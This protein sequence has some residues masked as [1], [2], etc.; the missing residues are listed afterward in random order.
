MLATWVLDAIRVDNIATNARLFIED[1]SNYVDRCF[2]ILENMN[3]TI[4]RVGKLL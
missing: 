1:K 3:A 2:R 4:G